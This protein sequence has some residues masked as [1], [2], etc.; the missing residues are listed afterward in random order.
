MPRRRANGA[1][2]AKAPARPAGLSTVADAVRRQAQSQGFVVAREIRAELARAGLAESLWKEVVA[3]AGA[4]LSCRRGRYY[5]VP[6]GPSRMRA[7]VRRDYRQHQHLAAAVRFLI[8]QQRALEAVHVERRQ[9]P[10][11]N[12]VCPVQVQTEDRRV[13]NLLSR[14]ISISGIRLI[15]TCGLQGQ[16]VHIWIPRPDNS[17]ERCC[18]L[19]HLLW[20]AAVG[21]GLYESGGI[22]VELVEAEPKPNPLKI[23]GRD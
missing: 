8:R 16:K 2:R 13:L 20:S 15:G 23:A 18:F 5:Y 12:F 19:V 17:A 14:E 9:H 21:D 10:R 7:R 6:A 4:T 11:I 3:H 22:F 1:A